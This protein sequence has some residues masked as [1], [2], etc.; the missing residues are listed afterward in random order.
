M[1]RLTVVG[2]VGLVGL[3]R[4]L[5]EKL[6]GNSWTTHHTQHATDAQEAS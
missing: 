3:P 2:V 1:E 4:L 6:Y 5:R